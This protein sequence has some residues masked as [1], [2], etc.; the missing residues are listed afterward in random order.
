MKTVKRFLLVMFALVV[1][2]GAPCPAQITLARPSGP[3]AAS[4]MITITGSGFGATK[5]DN[6]VWIGGKEAVVEAWSDSS[7]VAVVPVGALGSEVEVHLMG[8]LRYRY[9]LPMGTRKVT[10]ASANQD[11]SGNGILVGGIKIYDDQALQQA[12]NSARAQLAAIQVINGAA[13]NGQV[14]TLQGATLSQSAFALNLGTPPTPG[15]TTTTNSGNALNT[16]SL[17]TNNQQNSGNTV[18]SNSNGTNNQATNG[19]TGNN[20]T[21]TATGAAFSVQSTVGGTNSFQNQSTVTGNNNVQVTGPSTQLT[22][23]SN[24]QTQTTGPSLQMVTTQAASNPTPPTITPSTLALPSPFSPGASA[25][26]NEQLELTCEI[27]GF[28]LLLEGA[29]SDHYLRVMRGGSIEQRVRP[30]ATIGVPITI[31]PKKQNTEAVAEIILEVSA[32]D[33]QAHE[34]P[35]VTAILP[36]DKTYNVASITDKSVSIGGAVATQVI[37][38]GVSALWGHKSYFVV[39]DQDTVALQFPASDSVVT[40]FGWQIRPVLG[41]K[42]VTTGMR[43][44]FVQLAFADHANVPSYGRVRVTTAW[45]KYDTKRGIVLGE[46][47]GTHVTSEQWF[48]IPRFELNP[49]V[50]SASYEDNADGT[51]VTAVGS[52]G[53]AFLDGTFAKVGTLAFVPGTNGTVQ[54]PS[55]IRFVL[56]AIQLA[57]HNGYLVDRSGESTEIVDP[58][59]AEGLKVAECLRIGEIET[60]PAGAGLTKLTITVSLPKEALCVP[61]GESTELRNLVAVIGNQ[62]FGLRN[63]PYLSTAG[64]KLS[65]LVPTGL[66]QNSRHI[67]VKRLLW[68]RAFEDGKD[69]DEATFHVTPVVG[70]AT[71]VFQD[72]NNLQIALT[73]TGLMGLKPLLPTT[74][75]LDPQGDS[76]AI[77]N[78]ANS[79]LKGLKQ[80]VLT[81]DA[82]ELFLVTIPAQIS[83]SAP[84]LNAVTKG[85]ASITIPA[86]GPDLHTLSDVRYQEKSLAYDVAPKGESVVV[87]LR[88]VTTISGTKILTFVFSGDKKIQLS[89]SVVDSAVKVEQ[90]APSK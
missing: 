29:L 23:T 52:Q 83:P 72:D 31:A 19:G 78:V 9:T 32:A 8:N 57:T 38:L 76:G 81:D 2:C 82:H 43:N 46:I 50:G 15:I 62:V 21:V 70:A 56:P 10:G 67:T 53:G 40:R 87:D 74:A 22:T 79:A 44:C 33:P 71:V 27:T 60:N 6:S 66:L 30:R 80:M 64:D 11:A 41:Q 51:L 34:A 77:L 59:V 85:Q 5:G 13:I 49:V 17:G 84:Q 26:L 39:Q 45:R 4:G 16:S 73:G 90:A 55:G 25:I 3:A 47:P 7:I 35:I 48:D 58:R 63:L 20:N 75:R 24:N 69:L 14:G 12:L 86:F 54:D 42:V 61:G 36:R 68:G 89:L 18:T 28:E 1:A 37:N 65:F 88:P